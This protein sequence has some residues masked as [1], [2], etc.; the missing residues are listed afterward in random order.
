[1]SDA[2]QTII[3]AIEASTARP[4][5]KSGN[6]YRTLCPYH[7]GKHH[8]LSISDGTDRVLLHCHSNNCDPKDIL[9]SIGLK[10]NDIYHEQLTPAQAKRHKSIANDREIRNAFEQEILIILCWISDKN[11]LLFPIPEHDEERVLQ[12]M[13]RINTA[14]AH[15]IKEA[16]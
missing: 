7:G 3:N 6:G 11:R 1:M 2:Q 8:N 13:S 15:Y 10:I 12:A 9:E 16:S 4:V 14:T 5:R